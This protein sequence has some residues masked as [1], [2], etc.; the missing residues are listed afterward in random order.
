MPPDGTVE[1][2]ELDERRLDAKIREAE[3]VIRAWIAK[4]QNKALKVDFRPFRP[5]TSFE[6][7]HVSGS[8]RAGSSR[9]TSV[10]TSDF[11]CHDID[12]LLLTSAATIPRTFFW[13]MGPTAVNACYGWR[14][15]LTNH[16]SRGCSTRGFA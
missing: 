9:E 7:R 11:D 1:R 13:S 5:A 10:C 8:A 3:E 14:R 12:H 4:L 2:V 16:F 6:P 15:I